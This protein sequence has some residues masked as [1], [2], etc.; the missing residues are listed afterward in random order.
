VTKQLAAA[1]FCL[2]A[3]LLTDVAC[4]QKAALSNR[5]V[6]DMITAGLSDEV[7]VEKIRSTQETNFDTSLEGL[8]ALKAAKVSDAVVKVMVNPKSPI[9]T[10]RGTFPPNPSPSVPGFPSN[11]AVAYRRP[12]GSFTALEPCPEASF[13]S[14]GVGKFFL[15]QGI[16]GIKTKATY[17]D[18]E[19]PLRIADR[20][21]TFYLRSNS[22][23]GVFLVHLEKKS[24]HRELE[25]AGAAT[26]FNMRIGIRKEDIIELTTKPIVDGIVSIIPNTELSNGEYLITFDIEGGNSFDFGIAAAK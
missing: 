26:S 7:V 5:D 15:T 20:R 3:L 1:I 21:P 17:R 22:A 10:A 4:A 23:R 9:S 25:I 24:D 19:A 8:K 2:V 13:K 6:I 12:D 16:S 11:A 18:A 14:A